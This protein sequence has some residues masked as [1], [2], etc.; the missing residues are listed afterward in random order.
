MQ[1][2]IEVLYCSDTQSNIEVH[3]NRKT[4]KTIYGIGNL[5][6]ILH[7]SLYIAM[8]GREI[9]KHL[10]FSAIQ[11]N[12]EAQYFSDMKSN[13]VVHINRKINK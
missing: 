13:I 7:M 11:G 4:N 12:I 9:T 1:S 2:N 8:I 5:F 10:Y 6:P 3:I